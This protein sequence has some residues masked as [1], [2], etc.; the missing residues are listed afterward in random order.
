MASERFVFAHL[1]DAHVGAWPRN[2]KLRSLLRESVLR[3]IE[4]VHAV[5]AEFLLI[6]GYWLAEGWGSKINSTSACVDVVLSRR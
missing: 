3:S 4:Q 1:A 5:H 2:L 6:S